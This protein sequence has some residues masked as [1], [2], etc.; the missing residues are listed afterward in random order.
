MT[1]QC[2]LFL[3]PT[4]RIVFAAFNFLSCHS[5][6]RS[7]NPVKYTRPILWSMR[8]NPQDKVF[9]IT[10]TALRYSFERLLKKLGF[11]DGYCF[12]LFRHTFASLYMQ[13]N[14]NITDL[15]RILGHARIDQ[16]MRYSHFSPH[17]IRQTIKVMDGLVSLPVPQNLQL[18]QK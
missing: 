14:G 16:T 6:P 4:R 12:H 1:S 15:Q 2:P 17:Y 9:N 8:G 5:T 18:E 10:V 11:G 3:E 7:V 13:N